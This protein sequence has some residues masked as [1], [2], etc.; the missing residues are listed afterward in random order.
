MMFDKSVDEW[1]GW[2]GFRIILDEPFTAEE[3]TAF[4]RSGAT[5]ALKVDVLRTGK[6]ESDNFPAEGIAL[7]VNVGNVEK[8]G[9]HP[10]GRSQYLIGTLTRNN[11]WETITFRHNSANSN[12]I[13]PN[14]A[15]NESDMME[16]VPAGG[17]SADGGIYY[18]DNLRLEKT[19]NQS[20]LAETICDFEMNEEAL[21]NNGWTNVFDEDF[22]SDLGQWDVW[23]GGAYNNELQHYQESNLS[24]EQGNLLINARR[25]TVTGTEDPYS[26]NTKTF[27]F[28]SGRIESKVNFSAGIESPKIRMVARIKLPKGKGL[29]PAFWSYGEPWPTSGEIDIL[30]ARGGSPEEYHTNYFYGTNAGVNLVQ[31]ASAHIE[32]DSDLSECFHIY[33]VIWEENKLTYFLDGNIVHETEGGYVDQLFGKEQRV[34]LNVAV[35]GDFFGGL[36]TSEIQEGTMTIDYVRVYATN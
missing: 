34:V 31:N 36:N 9:E 22:S 12:D 3:F 15:D 6:D 35:G 29:W 33:E 2:N 13:D 19:A 5:Y 21:L 18:F 11:E 24:V 30:E 8:Y 25:E 20:G 7:Y 1:D 4:G 14:V 23:N 16:V 17:L 10:A 27:D 32:T 28:T 26:E